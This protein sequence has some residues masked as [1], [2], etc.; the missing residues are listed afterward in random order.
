MAKTLGARGSIVTDVLLPN[1][2]SF[3]VEGNTYIA[4]QESLVSLQLGIPRIHT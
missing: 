1:S 4:T 3:V 2:L